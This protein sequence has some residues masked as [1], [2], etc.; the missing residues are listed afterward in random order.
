MGFQES[1]GKTQGQLWTSHT[2]FS[3]PIPLIALYCTHSTTLSSSPYL[4]SCI[5]IIFP[6]S[7]HTHYFNSHSRVAA[8]CRPSFP[9]KNSFLSP[10]LHSCSSVHSLVWKQVFHEFVFVSEAAQGVHAVQYVRVD[11]VRGGQAAD[12]HL[13]G[14]RLLWLR[15]VLPPTGNAKRW[16]HRQPF[17][18]PWHC[19]THFGKSEQLCINIFIYL[20][21]LIERGIADAQ[22]KWE[23]DS[24]LNISVCVCLSGIWG[25]MFTSLWPRLTLWNFH[26][27]EFSPGLV[28]LHVIF[29][30]WTVVIVL[31]N[32]NTDDWVMLLN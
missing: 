7:T 32:M 19:T 4:S 17:F 13:P 24:G 20:M 3:S 28:T 6:M 21:Q 25:N 31:T 14:H 11:I 26:S 16:G 23:K 1:R 30:G 29:R 12:R 15:L 18:V 5:F 22:I 2:H 8:N 27:H 10:S 9:R